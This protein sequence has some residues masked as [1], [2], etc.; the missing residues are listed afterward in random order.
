MGP[1]CYPAGCAKEADGLGNR[2]VALRHRHPA[3][4]SK[5]AEKRLPHIAGAAR[6]DQHFRQMPPAQR[7]GGVRAGQASSSNGT[8]WLRNLS[9][10]S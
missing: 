5:I 7:N 9:T 8:P 1:T 3:M 4:V 10:I 2:H 6:L